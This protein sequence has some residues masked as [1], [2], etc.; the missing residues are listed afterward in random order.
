MIPRKS[1][2][3]YH[4]KLVTHLKNHR[5]KNEVKKKKKDLAYKNI[6]V[7]ILAY[8]NTKELKMRISSI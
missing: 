5:K 2:I 7:A 1:K 6:W 3:S 8:S 4:L